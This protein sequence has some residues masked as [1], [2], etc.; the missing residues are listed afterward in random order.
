MRFTVAVT[1]LLSITPL[2]LFVCPGDQLLFHLQPPNCD[3]QNDA[4]TKKGCQLLLTHFIG[5]HLHS[6]EGTQAQL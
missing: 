5:G 1:Q 6:T 3:V 4:W 2:L